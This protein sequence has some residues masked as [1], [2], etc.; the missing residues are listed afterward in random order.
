MEL[1]VDDYVID[2]M[3][4]TTPGTTIAQTLAGHAEKADPPA[5]QAPKAKKAVRFKAGKQLEQALN[6]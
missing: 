2:T 1:F 3:D 5:V 4:V 6:K